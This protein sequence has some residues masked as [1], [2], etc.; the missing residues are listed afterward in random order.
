MFL[1]TTSHGEYGPSQL[2]ELSEFSIS[3]PTTDSRRASD[4]QEP[5]LQKSPSASAAVAQFFAQNSMRL[6]QQDGYCPAFLGTYLNALVLRPSEILFLVQGHGD[7]LYDV[8]ERG[9]VQSGFVK[10]RRAACMP[11]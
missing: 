6:L 11:T 2:R 9:S 5:R 10:E 8:P 1:A 3:L 7:L 4:T